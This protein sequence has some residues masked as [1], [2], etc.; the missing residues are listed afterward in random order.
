MPQ[1]PSLDPLDHLGGGPPEPL[2]AG[3]IRGGTCSN[4]TG[5][6]ALHHANAS[7]EDTTRSNPLTHCGLATGQTHRTRPEFRRSLQKSDA[8]PSIS[9]SACSGPAACDRSA[10]A[11]D[12]KTTV[13]PDPIPSEPAAL[14]VAPPSPTAFPQQQYSTSQSSGNVIPEDFLSALTSSVSPAPPSSPEAPVRPHQA[15]SQPEVPQAGA[16]KAPADAVIPDET[17]FGIASLR[18]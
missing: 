1:S 6:C 7:G 12:L 18:M 8:G 15:G 14:P 5:A 10:S 11:G 4:D 2:D 13:L 3:C 9:K 17:D 16:A